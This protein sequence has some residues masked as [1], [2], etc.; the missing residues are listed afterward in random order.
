M[1]FRTRLP[2]DTATLLL[3][4]ASHHRPARSLEHRRRPRERAR[5]RRSR[6]SA[7]S[8]LLAVYG[9]LALGLPARATAASRPLERRARRPF[10]FATARRRP[11]R[12]RRRARRFVSDWFVSALDPAVEALGI[13]K[14][15]TGIVI[16]GI[17]GNA[18]ENVVGDHAR[19]ARAVRPRDLGRSRTRSRR[20]RPSCSPCLV[21]VSLFFDASPD[22]RAR[23]R[24]HQA[25]S[26]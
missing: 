19:R 17:A 25:H 23:A 12:R 13:S 8:C 11:R 24:V 7:R 10:S 6:R 14:A 26:R 16:V 3:L 4:A 2:N 5:G 18:V 9:V 21:L 15:F 22:V 20:S 1:R